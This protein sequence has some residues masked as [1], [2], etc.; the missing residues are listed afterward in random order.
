MA[1]N[2]KGTILRNVNR[3]LTRSAS[4]APTVGAKTHPD[5]MPMDQIENA[6]VRLSDLNVSK[7]TA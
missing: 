3:Q 5:T 1:T 6:M 4:Q 2:P 7:V